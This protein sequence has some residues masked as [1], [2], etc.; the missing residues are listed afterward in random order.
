MG[1]ERFAFAST[2][3]VVAIA[4]CGGTAAS[5]S[6]AGSEITSYQT[7]AATV[8]SVSATYSTT[9]LGPTSEDCQRIHDQ[10]DAQV[11]PIVSQIVQ[12]GGTMDTFLD[13]QGAATSADMRCDSATMMDELDFHRSVACT[14]SGLNAN[15][16]EATRHADAMS[17]FAGHILDRCDEM[18]AAIRGTTGNATGNNWAPMMSGCERWSATC[19]SAMM[20]SGCCGGNMGRDGMTNGETCCGSGG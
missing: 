9:M 18:L 15:Q 19:C 20:R 3:A 14:F 5:S 8:Q 7:L 16:A 12:M 6:T 2:F 10:Y 4:A 13:S 17:S 11:R 1:T